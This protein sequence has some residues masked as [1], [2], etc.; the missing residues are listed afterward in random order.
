MCEIVMLIFGIITLIRGRFLLLRTK[1]VLGWPARIVGLFLIMPFPLSFLTGMV[2][3]AIWMAM[4]KNI[5]DRGFLDAARIA[6]LAIVF[7]CF[8]SAIGMAMY[9][10]E[11]VRKRRSEQEIAVLP[12]DYDERFQPGAWD[13]TKSEGITGAPSPPPTAPD[14]RIQP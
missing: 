9:F 7:L 11:P 10:A 1:E 5:D 4:G 14:D 6:E 8:V 2:L 13:N 3:G 12:E